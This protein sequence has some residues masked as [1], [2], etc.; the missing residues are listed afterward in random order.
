[1]KKK[2][3]GGIVA[4]CLTVIL[5]TILV[6]VA[7]DRGIFEAL[8]AGKQGDTSQG[9]S[10][11]GSA[12][13]P[14]GE[15]A[16]SGGPVRVAVEETVTTLGMS[17][18]VT[19]V[20]VSKEPGPL[21]YRDYKPDIVRDAAGVIS[22]EYSYVRLRLRIEN[23]SAGAQRLSLLNYTLRRVVGDHLS[24]PCE[25]YTYDAQTNVIDK[26]Y[27]LYTLEDGAT[28]DTVCGF[29]LSDDLLAG[30]HFDLL[31]N[32]AGDAN[33]QTNEDTRYIRIL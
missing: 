32:N 5:A 33:Y 27:F 19:D 18:T 25:M 9:S 4:G 8:A 2:V 10:G 16:P 15:D 14:D 13:S 23:H 6:S 21:P 30:N 20:Q 26:G 12:P 17:Y 31:I 29:I 7:R 1:M 3:R 11:G 22:N 24:S 28:L